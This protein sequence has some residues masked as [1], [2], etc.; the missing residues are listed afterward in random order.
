MTK[1]RPAATFADA[2]TRVAGRIGWAGAA[3][4]V[5]KAERTVRNWSDPDTGALPTVED[6]LALDRAYLE[7]GGTSPPL[8][9]VMTLRLERGCAIGVD[10]AGLA[11]ATANAAREGGEALAALSGL[12]GD[13]VSPAAREQARRELGEAIEAL[14]T[15]QLKLGP[16]A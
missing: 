7:A 13:T 9:G 5:G 11:I 3:D 10:R 1:I 2:V 12:L 6:A 8:L 4:A 14:Q 16:A 15:A